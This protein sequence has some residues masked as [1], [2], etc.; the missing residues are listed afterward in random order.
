MCRLDGDAVG[1]LSTRTLAAFDESSAAA[2]RSAPSRV[3]AIGFDGFIRG[4]P[5][6]AT[7]EGRY[8][9]D[10]I[11]FADALYEVIGVPF[12]RDDF[13]QILHSLATGGRVVPALSRHDARVLKEIGFVGDPRAATAARLDRDIRMT[14]LVR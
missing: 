8:R 11:P 12:G 7:G 3:P 13:L 4:C 1:K 5:R 2:S 9:N 6:F 10:A 14:E